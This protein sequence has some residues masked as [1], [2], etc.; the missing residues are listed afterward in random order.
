MTTPWSSWHEVLDIF[1][2]LTIQGSGKK[3]AYKPVQAC[4]HIT[5]TVALPIQDLYLKENGFR[6]LYLSRLSQHALEN[7]FSDIGQENPVLQPA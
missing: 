4:A 1:K 7:L 2:R 5:T 6:Y 3:P